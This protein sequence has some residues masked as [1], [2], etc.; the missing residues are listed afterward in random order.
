VSH[1]TDRLSQ[2]DLRELARLLRK[3]DARRAARLEREQLEREQ[4]DDRP[5]GGGGD[6]G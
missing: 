3:V 6:A 5:E 2:D 4:Q 1:V